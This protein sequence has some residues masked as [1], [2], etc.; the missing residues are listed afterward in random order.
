MM[1]TSSQSTCGLLLALLC[2]LMVASSYAA[3]AGDYA[4]WQPVANQRA[5]SSDA[6]V[7]MV[8]YLKQSNLDRLD[9]L[10]W[11]VSD[12]DSPIYAQYLSIDEITEIVAAPAEAVKTVVEWL[13]EH[14]ATD[15]HVVKNRDALIARM[16]ATTAD[17]LFSVNLRRFRSPDGRREILRSSKAYALPGHVARHVDLISG[18]TDFPPIQDRKPLKVKDNVISHNAPS[19]VAANNAPVVTSAGARGGT[20]I[21]IRFNPRC[22]NGFFT[23]TPTTPCADYPPAIVRFEA[24]LSSVSDIT[25]R[26]ELFP[27]WGSDFK[28]SLADDRTECEI[29]VKGWYYDQVNV[30]LTSYYSANVKSSA[31]NYEY[32]VLATPP[33]VPQSIWAQYNIPSN[34]RVTTNVTQ[35]VVE[36]EQQYYSPS[37]LTLF[38][39]QMGLPTDTPVTVIGPNYPNQ[40]GGEANLDIQYI[41]GVAPGAAT[42]F[43]SIFA[44][45]SLEID[46]ILKWALQMSETENPPQV[47]SLSYGMAEINVDTYLGKGYLARSD[48]EFKKLALRGITLIFASGDTGAGLLGPAPMT[49]PNCDTLHADWPCQSAYVTGVSSTIITPVSEPICYLPKNKGGIDCSR[50]PL[51]EIV[52]SVDEGLFWTTGGGFSNITQRAPYQAD[53]VESYL[54]RK[55]VAFP[56]SDLMV[57]LSG[58]FIP[59][60]GTSASAPI[61]AGVVTLLNDARVAAGLPP[62]GFLNPMLYKAR[63]ERPQTFYDVVWGNNRCGAIG[64]PA[65]APTCCAQGFHAVDGWD[66]ATG[67]GTPNFLELRDFVLNYPKKW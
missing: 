18:L 59:V 1:F 51:G 54:A 41:M 43:W 55:D 14:G 11:A 63:R 22:S 15:I 40:P 7:R 62:L 34:T 38:F 47:N 36:F 35:C 57:A 25:K 45:S 39:E 32:S 26:S 16:S 49:V 8:V 42:T 31:G 27:I 4:G 20:D 53:M 48:F 37:D 12:P 64:L 5:L 21:R 58:Q 66:A 52:V 65:P 56:P 28:C 61:F 10:F 33:I 9:E 50:N 6:Q 29:D 60:D 30:S 19:T 23:R 24:A 67:L 2:C 13:A 17:A 3:P 44:N 46:D